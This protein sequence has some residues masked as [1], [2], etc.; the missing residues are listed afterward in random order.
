MEEPKSRE[1]PWGCSGGEEMRTMAER[2]TRRWRGRGMDQPCLRTALRAFIFAILFIA[3]HMV[4]MLMPILLMRK[5]SPYF[6]L[7]KTWFLVVNLSSRRET[8][9]WYLP[10]I[11]SFRLA[12]FL[13]TFLQW[14]KKKSSLLLNINQWNYSLLDSSCLKKPAERF[15]EWWSREENSLMGLLE[16]ANAFIFQVSEPQIKLWCQEVCFGGAT[17]LCPGTPRRRGG[18]S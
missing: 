18:A 9:Q 13:R 6:L 7:L 3:Q 15:L 2:W 12:Q 1:P 4:N 17:P 10:S 5:L 8:S 14:P 11:G 16:V